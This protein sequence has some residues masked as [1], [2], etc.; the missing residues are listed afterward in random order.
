MCCSK[1]NVLMFILLM[2]QS[3]ARSVFLHGC[4]GEGCDTVWG[5]Q[6]QGD[7]CPKCDGRRYDDKGKPQEFVLHFPLKSRI[8]SLL[9]CRAYQNAVRWECERTHANDDYVSG[10]CNNNYL[11][12]NKNVLPA[13][14]CVRLRRLERT[15]GTTRSGSARPPIHT[16]SNGLFSLH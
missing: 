12:Q 4:V 14:R 15:D 11:M 1:Q 6:D 8:E 9:T 3:G 16:D 13:C 2:S 10:I 5:P 7:I